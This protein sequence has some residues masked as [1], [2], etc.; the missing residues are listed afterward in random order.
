M[1]ALAAVLAAS[2]AGG[3]DR[4]GEEECRDAVLNIREITQVTERLDESEVEAAIRSCRAN[5]SAE[6]VECVREAETLDDLVA[7]EGEVAE[8]VVDEAEEA[9][10]AE[11][12]D[13]GDEADEGEDGAATEDEEG[14]GGGDSA[15]AGPDSD[16]P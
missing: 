13:G 16:E 14:A 11:E 12:A 15:E 5:A 6:S 8:D 7:C 3:C 1:T 4:P 10:R 2:L 9:E